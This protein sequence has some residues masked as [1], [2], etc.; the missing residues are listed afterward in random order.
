MLLAVPGLAVAQTWGTVANISDTMGVNTGRVCLG[1]ASRQDIGCPTYAPSVTTGGQFIA[2]SMATGGLTVTGATSLST[3]SATIGDFTTL[4][5][6]GVPVGTGTGAGD[7]ISSSNSQAMALATDGGTISFTLGGTAGRAYLDTTLGLVAPAVSTTGN[8]NFMNVNMPNVI[9]SSN[10]QLRLNGT[11]FAHAYQA[12]GTDGQNTFMGLF[13]GNTTMATAGQTWHASYNTGLGN[14]SLVNLTSGY[15]NTAVGY[16]S[17]YSN[18]SGYVNTAFGL[19]TLYHNSTGIGNTA[20]GTQASQNNTTGNNNVAVGYQAGYYMTTG[21]QNTT[22]G[23]FS[24]YDISSSNNNTI[25]GYNTGRGII[26]GGNN[27][28]IGSLVTGLAAG[29]SNN[30]IIADGAGNRR[31]NVDASG[32]VGINTVTPTARL[33]VAGDTNISGTLRATNFIGDGSGLTGI[34]ASDNTRVAK[35]GDTMTGSLYVR[36]P[37]L[38]MVDLVNG[39]ASA[40]GYI[41]FSTQDGVRRGYIGWHDGSSRMQIASEN[42]WNYSFTQAPLVASNVM[43]HAGNDGAGSG[44]DADLLDGLSSA[45]F[46]RSNASDIDQW[47]SFRVM[48]NATTGSDGMYIGYGNANSARTRIYSSG[49]TGGHY[50]SDVAG[51]ILRSDDAT[52]WHSANDGAGSGLDADTVDGVNP[53][54]AFVAKAGDTMTG[55]LIG[56]PTAGNFPADGSAATSFEVRSNGAGLAA[57]TMAFHRPGA[58][59]AYFGLGNDN[60]WRVGGWSMGATSFRLW[61]EGND[62]TG[63]GLDADTVDGWNPTVSNGRVTMANVGCAGSWASSCDAGNN[64]YADYADA[65]GTATDS[66][67]VAKAGDTMTGSLTVQNDLSITGQQE[68]RNANPTITM[69]DTDHRTGYIH[70]NS[71]LMYFMGSSGSDQG[72]G[73]WSTFPLYLNLINNDA[74]FGGAVTANAYYYSSDGRLK[75]NIHGIDRKSIEDLYSL[76]GVK[77]EWDKTGKA[78]IGLIAQEVQRIFP[79]LVREGDNG[80]LSIKYGNLVPILL[81]AAKQQ[82]LEI[83]TLKDQL[84]AQ[85]KR[86]KALEAKVFGK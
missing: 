51:N 73:N 5:V 35:A 44:L 24:G 13:S 27:T 30:V 70:T 31:I 3:I 63:S 12:T 39:S 6:N 45:S 78:D 2:T 26:T 37:T 25:V 43:W 38:G 8:G 72:Y 80:M 54:T 68:I 48:R 19:N 76:R 82:N 84:E 22:L 4:R 9:G 11:R 57:A 83:D 14:L 20:F 53:S 40:P 10:G 7:R 34:A 77:F 49:S 81:E 1:E 42:G 75:K 41:Q 61:H 32:N 21:S 62:G 50:Y 18:T 69:R 15:Y 46:A 58:Y 16:A 33:T 56:N 71:N 66:T 79:E 47:L 36:A 17:L 52:Y 29:L 55:N 65:A 28:I 85:Q 74:V 59:A 64:G 67:K 60:N 23:N 86:L